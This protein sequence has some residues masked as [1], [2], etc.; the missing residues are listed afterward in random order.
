MILANIFKD[1]LSWQWHP[2][3]QKGREKVFYIIKWQLKM[4]IENLDNYVV[5]FCSCCLGLWQRLS[6]I[7]VCMSVYMI[8]K[9][10]GGPHITQN[11]VC[12]PKW[13]N[14]VP[15]SASFSIW[16]LRIPSS[17]QAVSQNWKLQYRVPRFQKNHGGYLIF[18]SISN[19]L[20]SISRLDFFPLAAV[21]FP[22]SST[23]PHAHSFQ[24]CISNFLLDRLHAS[25][26]K[27][28]FP[29]P[30]PL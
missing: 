11:R 30:S 24:S 26:D 7:Y 5:F 14:E 23:N 2:W 10:D 25:F 18:F 22:F 12:T 21:E 15:L 4:K 16:W 9:K 20:V 29:I 27:Y 19:F 13:N 28:Q 1:Q 3:L 8:S 17:M 6:N